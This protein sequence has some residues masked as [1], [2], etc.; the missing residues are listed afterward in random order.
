MAARFLPESDEFSS[1]PRL[2][3]S[4]QLVTN[5]SLE[6][7]CSIRRPKIKP[8]YLIWIKPLYLKERPWSGTTE[9][10]DVLFVS[11]CA[12]NV[13]K[14]YPRFDHII[15]LTAPADLILDRLGTLTNN[16]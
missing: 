7:I 6:M 5:F 11:G 1:E 9:D 16:S 12:A 2:L 14:F 10:V 8:L 13:F 3:S 15:L 4:N